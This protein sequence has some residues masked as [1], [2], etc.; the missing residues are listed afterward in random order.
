MLCAELLEKAAPWPR[1]VSRAFWI[2]GLTLWQHK[3]LEYRNGLS[4]Y[5]K[6]CDAQA[7]CVKHV[8]AT[9]I[10]WIAE[11]RG[12]VGTS[13]LRPNTGITRPFLAPPA[14]FIGTAGM[15]R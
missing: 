14:R 7:S 10:G 5:A 3:L 15:Q 8:G 12:V 1:S 4:G 2:D 13:K 11:R 6:P 9:L